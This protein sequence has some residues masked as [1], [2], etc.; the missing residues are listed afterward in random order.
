MFTV[1]KYCFFLVSP[2]F[3]LNYFSSNYYFFL[4]TVYALS[5]RARIMPVR[6]VP[7]DLE[8]KPTDLEII[9]T[10]C[11]RMW[12]LFCI[13]A[14]KKW[15]KNVLIIYAPRSSHERSECGSVQTSLPYYGIFLH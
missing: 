11:L 2:S 6:E 10:F 5:L 9:P 8:I 1:Q 4:L 15:G 3:F 14:Q 13:F 7:T 12:V